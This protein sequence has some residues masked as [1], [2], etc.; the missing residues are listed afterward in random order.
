MRIMQRCLPCLRQ[1][2]G[3]L[4]SA[5]GANSGAIISQLKI[6]SSERAIVRRVL[7]LQYTEQPRGSAPSGYGVECK[8]FRIKIWS[9][10]LRQRRRGR[11]KP[12]PVL[13]KGET[14]TL[15]GGP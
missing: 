9:Q 15:C 8:S 3:R 4:A 11:G 12:A 5:S 1:Q 7:T 2:G 10:Q 6:V 13:K 14:R